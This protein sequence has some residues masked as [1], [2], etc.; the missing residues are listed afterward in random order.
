MSK[1]NIVIGTINNSANPEQYRELRPDE[2]RAI[3]GDQW[4]TF[5]AVGQNPEVNAEWLAIENHIE[6][7][8]YLNME[9][10][11]MMEWGLLPPDFKFENY[12][13]SL[14]VDQ[15][16]IPLD[17]RFDEDEKALDL[18]NNPDDISESVLE[19]YDEIKIG[20]EKYNVLYANENGKLEVMDASG[21]VLSAQVNTEDGSISIVSSEA[22]PSDLNNEVPHGLSDAELLAAGF[23]STQL[24]KSIKYDMMALN[25]SKAVVNGEVVSIG[26]HTEIMDIDEWMKGNKVPS[27]IVKV[28]GYKG[29]KYVI[30]SGSIVMG[31]KQIRGTHNA[32]TK[33]REIMFPSGFEYPEGTGDTYKRH[34]IKIPSNITKNMLFEMIVN[35]CYSL[36][37]EAELPGVKILGE[38]G[39][40][41]AGPPKKVTV[42]YHT[43]RE[44]MTD[45]LWDI[46][47]KNKDWVVIFG[48]EITFPTDRINEKNEK[49]LSLDRQIKRAISIYKGG[50][51]NMDWNNSNSGYYK[52]QNGSNN[53][54]L[55]YFYTSH[56]RGQSY[57][58]L[59]SIN[60]RF[61][62][63]DYK[64]GGAYKDMQNP[65]W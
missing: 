20:D 35:P 45:E 60:Q 53:T 5:S 10:N 18:T 42:F 32:I 27:S 64:Y 28:G 34:K 54:Y 50:I 1:S 3:Y 14:G 16:G 37:F 56:P 11:Q 6:R 8:K 51:N 47:N 62:S 43:L 55:E 22:A 40:R 23:S 46:V 19:I 65:D 41:K 13:I 48:D 24:D 21:D 59:N 31:M 52:G 30:P 49:K 58:Y 26:D 9:F 17:E 33:Q 57:K 2:I 7:N 36:T 39:I 15:F 12:L 29:H 38:G 25:N 4:T 44:T 61:K 63:K